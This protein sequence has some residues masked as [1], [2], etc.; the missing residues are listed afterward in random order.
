MYSMT[1]YETIPH[2]THEFP[3]EYHYL[4]TTHPRYH[5][6]T[7]W[8]KEWELIRVLDGTFTAHVDEEE[9]VLHAGEMLLV[10][11][12]ML[13][14][15]I[16][17]DCIYECF[18]FDLHGLFRSFE[19]VKKYLRPFY[20]MEVLPKLLFTKELH[21]DIYNAADSLLKANYQEITAP[22]FHNCRELISV[23]CLGQLFGL[24][25][26]HHLYTNNPEHSANSSQRIGQIKSVLEY[27]EQNFASP[28]TLDILADI[29]GVNPKYFCRIFKEITHQTPMDYVILYRIEQ[30]AIRLSTTDLP[31][32]EI[33]MDCGFNDCSYFIRTF[34]KHMKMTPN[35]YRAMAKH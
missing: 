35:K 1:Y 2:G 7:H 26:Q 14:G 20:R 19:H 5:M 32:I 22:D 33:G 18:L 10:R 29:A 3:A 34:K 6:S 25:L 12:S 13:H 15:G 27:V 4:D 17:T 28:I 9:F 23:S 21:P 31:I 16:A 30:A 24:I 8:H 11:D